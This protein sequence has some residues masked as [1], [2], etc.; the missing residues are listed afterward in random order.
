MKI[1]AILLL[2]TLSAATGCA[3][4]TTTPLT[5]HDTDTI[6]GDSNGKRDKLCRTRTYRGIPIKVKS[7]THVDIWVDEQYLLVKGEKFEG[8]REKPLPHKLYSVRTEAVIGEH[9]VITDF[10]RPA[11]GLL[12]V[13]LDFNDEQYVQK[14]QSQLVD[15]TITDSA[16]LLATIIQKTG[17]AALSAVDE[18]KNLS[19]SE[20]YKWKQRTVAYQRF[21][22]NAPDFEQQIEAFIN[23]HL[24]DCNQ[25]ATM[26]SYD[27]MSSLSE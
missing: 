22:I 25:C 18:S 9:V 20:N 17:I 3:S 5:R 10:K 6:S 19:D 8:W 1:Q 26:P 24:N 14:I 7:Q 16:D 13:T 12:D 23:Q 27:V 4:F 21:D 2:G 11:S 15:D